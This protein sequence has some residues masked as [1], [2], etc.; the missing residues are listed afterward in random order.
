MTIYTAHDNA[1]RKFRAVEADRASDAAEIFAARLARRAFGRR[2][3]AVTVRPNGSGGR[4]SHWDVFVGTS[5]RGGG[6]AG[7]NEWLYVTAEVR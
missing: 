3:V 4:T 5:C 1:G 2:G 6:Y 7:R